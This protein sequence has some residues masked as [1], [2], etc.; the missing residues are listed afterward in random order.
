MHCS[1]P[2]LPT[3][4]QNH[5]ND[6]K[7]QN[8]Y[9]VNRTSQRKRDTPG[10][11]PRPSTVRR[12]VRFLQDVVSKSIS[13]ARLIPQHQITIPCTTTP[14]HQARPKQHCKPGRLGGGGGGGAAPDRHAHDCSGGRTTCYGEACTAYLTGAVGGEGGGG[15]ALLLSSLIEGLDGAMIVT[16][17]PRCISGRFICVHTL[18]SIVMLDEDM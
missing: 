5:I 12:R 17:V 14:K 3:P 10:N 2:C 4:P 8:H 13:H 11:I 15:D 6:H 16:Y 18:F 7:V 9:S 1:P